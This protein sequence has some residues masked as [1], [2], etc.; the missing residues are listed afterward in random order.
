LQAGCGCSLD[1]VG[2]W[3]STIFIKGF[4]V[5]TAYMFWDYLFIEDKEF[6]FKILLAI[7]I[8]IKGRFCRVFSCK[9]VFL[10]WFAI[11]EQL[12]AKNNARA[13]EKLLDVR[14]ATLKVDSI[15]SV[16]E[17]IEIPLGWID[18]LLPQ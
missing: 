16:A 12:M 9:L 6:L 8:S 17:S 15:V 18:T 4:P 1:V 14:I 5:T 7:F 2:D 11:A 10:K 3:L 13:I